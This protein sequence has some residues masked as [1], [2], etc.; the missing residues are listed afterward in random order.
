MK[1]THRNSEDALFFRDRT[2]GA[3]IQ[4]NVNN[5]IFYKIR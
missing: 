2:R 5:H 3:E 4:Y 1:Q